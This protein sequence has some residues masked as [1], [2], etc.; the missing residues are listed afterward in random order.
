MR[1]LPEHSTLFR[2][3]EE[4]EK[5]LVTFRLGSRRRFR[6]T[7]ILGAGAIT[8]AFLHVSEAKPIV[9]VSVTLGIMVVNFLL[10]QFTTRADRHRPWHRYAFATL[11]VV[12]VSTV[13]MSFGN[14]ALVVLYFLIIVPYSF[15]RGRSLGQYTAVLST[16][17]FLTSSWLFSAMNPNVAARPVWTAVAAGL[18]P[19]NSS[20]GSA[21]RVTTSAMRN[22]AISRLGWRVATRTSS[23]F[24]NEVSIACSS[25]SVP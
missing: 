13:V 2:G 11:D 24:C 21:T 12:L 6:A 15:D 9:A 20:G 8:A 7:A 19:R 23:G 5:D 1:Q 14:E 10:T 17:A 25:S 3:D 4:H 18:L 16:S 22:T